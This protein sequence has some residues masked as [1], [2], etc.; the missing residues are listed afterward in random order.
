MSVV[1]GSRSFLNWAEESAFNSGVASGG[2]WYN[3]PII[4]EG[5]G[6]S[7]NPIISTQIQPDR[8]VPDARGG[9]IASDGPI[10]TDFSLTRFLLFFKHLLGATSSG[11]FG[12]PAA[13]VASTAYTRGTVKLGPAPNTKVYRCITSGSTGATPA[14]DFVVNDGSTFTSGTSEWKWLIDTGT[15][16]GAL[17]T[18][19]PTLPS[20][21]LLFEKGVIATSALQYLT[22]SG[23]RIE[24]LQL[25]IPQD[26]ICQAVWNMIPMRSASSASSASG[27]PSSPTDEGVLGFEAGLEIINADSSVQYVVD[28]KTGSLSIAN[29]FETDDYR[30]GSRNRFDLVEKRRVV[31]GDLDMYMSDITHYNRF[32]AETKFGLRFSWHHATEYLSITL[33]EVKFFGDPVAKIGGE[34]SVMARFAFTPFR[35]SASFDCQVSYDTI[36]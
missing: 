7:V 16:A 26:N 3:L 5:L 19:S 10:T 15:R 17:Y 13:L 18:G 28:I 1:R 30:W 2:G 29:N 14:T 23:V 20:A 36:A 31:S 32:K 12:A 11:S 27:T 8:T 35:L 24:S 33:P 6:E 25:T 9:N 4:S 34:G 21:G 22:F